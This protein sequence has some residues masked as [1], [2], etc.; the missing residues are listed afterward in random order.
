VT[1]VPLR[2]YLGRGLRATIPGITL[3]LCIFIAS[4]PMGLPYLSDVTPFLSLMAVYYWS[5]YRP[6]LIPVVV[7]FLAGLLQ[8]VLIGGP[9]G[10]LAL[11]LVLVHGVGVSQRGVFLG[12]T[13]QVEW[14]GFGLV[15]V[16]AILF[17]WAVASIYFTTLIDSRAFVVQALLTV[18]IY[19]LVTRLFSLAARGLRAV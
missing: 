18:A 5:I 17:A 2:I 9:V 13:F 10:L 11:V 4:V 15:T 16:G 8:D 7:V 1:D 12:K 3:L 19:P 14:W 6:D